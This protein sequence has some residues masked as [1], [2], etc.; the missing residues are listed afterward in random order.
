MAKLPEDIVA[1]LVALRRALHRNAEPSGREERTA[2]LLADAVAAAEPDEVVAGLGGHGVAAV[3]AGAAD[4]P[5]VLVRADMDALPLP[6]SPELA[7]ASENEGS[8]HKCGHDGHMAMLTGLAHLLAARRPARGRVVLLYQPAEETGAGAARVLGDPAFAPL[9][10]DRVLAL[11]NL[12]GFPLGTVVLR[13]GPFA[14]ASRGLIVGLRGVTSHAAEPEAGRSPALAAA[15][16]VQALAAAPQNHTALHEAAQVTI[17]GIDVGGPAFGTSP[18]RG[19]V[20]ATLRSSREEVMDR[21][22]ARCGELARGLAASFGLDCTVEWTEIFPAVVNDAAAV[23][24]VRRVAGELGLEVVRPD[25]PFA[26]SEDFGHF[27]SVCPGALFGLGAGVDLPALHHPD[28]DFPDALIPTG[29][30]ML[31]GALRV[32][33]EEPIG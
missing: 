1:D 8:A 10:P 13:E 25:H 28:Y 7:Y 16:L 31:D 17:V 27:T 18:G 4:G 33:L 23:A 24:A 21:L 5:T 22:A 15:A 19:R 9:R 11:H 26:W 6:D 12:P 20:M 2:A 30:A 3:Y 32:L 29:S 14:G